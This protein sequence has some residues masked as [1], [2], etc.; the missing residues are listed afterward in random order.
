MS[1]VC[2]TDFGRSAIRASDIAAGLAA[3]LKTKLFLVH[4][5]EP[6]MPTFIAGEPIVLEPSLLHPGRRAIEKAA[7]RILADEA[8][9]LRAASG[10]DVVPRISIGGAEGVLLDMVRETD[11]ELVVAGTWGRNAASRFVVGSTTD[12]LARACPVPLLVTRGHSDALLAWSR[13]DGTL[14]LLVGVDGDGE[15]FPAA[16]LKLFHGAG[17][18]EIDYANVF[19]LPPA[20]FYGFEGELAVPLATPSDLAGPLGERIGRIAGDAGLPFAPARLHFLEGGVA[21]S[22]EEL[23]AKGPFDVLFAGTHARRGLKRW[24][25]GSTA[26]GLLHGAPCPVVIEPIRPA[27]K[28]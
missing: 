2:G 1:I 6:P 21:A 11:A 22:L 18:C 13:G 14:R 8:A 24:V 25:L 9:R 12:R 4:A 17:A 28:D 26:L 20:A 27:T 15:G 16:A 10:A 3:R 7:D 19:G 5:L 23:A